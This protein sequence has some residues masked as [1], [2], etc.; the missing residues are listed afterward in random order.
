VTAGI[1]GLA[2][3]IGG[4]FFS[5][6]G[7]PMI[8]QNADILLLGPLLFGPISILYLEAESAVMRAGYYSGV[9]L[10]SRAKELCGHTDRGVLGWESFRATHEGKLSAI[11][12]PDN[13]HFS[14][15]KIMLFELP[16]LVFLGAYIY[17]RISPAG[18]LFTWHPML[19]CLLLVVDTEIV[20]YCIDRFVKALDDVRTLNN[21]AAE[22][23]F[24]VGN[25]NVR[26]T[27]TNVNT[28]SDYLNNIGRWGG[29]LNSWLYRLLWLDGVFFLAFFCFLP[30]VEIDLQHA[31]QNRILYAGLAI[32]IVGT[33]V[34]SL[35][36][37][38][39][40]ESWYWLIPM[41]VCCAIW[42]FFWWNRNLY[43][44]PMRLA[45]D[46]EN[47]DLA[48]QSILKHEEQ[49]WNSPG[50]RSAESD[51]LPEADFTTL[52]GQTFQA[53]D[54][55]DRLNYTLG[56]RLN[57]THMRFEPPAVRDMSP[58]V[59]SLDVDQ[60]VTGLPQS[61]RIMNTTSKN[62]LRIHTKYLLVQKDGSWR[63]ASGQSTPQID[64]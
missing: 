34:A 33:L 43:E 32:G 62:V 13:L 58:G 39:K 45:A 47:G 18:Y 59:K 63:I 24:E 27:G 12:R 22:L 28:R 9:E 52:D 1:G 55:E 29:L 42:G 31:W 30:A 4:V 61:S 26:S 5:Q 48:V 49:A 14:L 23:L 53:R 6:Y 50:H 36:S 3:T 54:I 11:S 40:R 51:Y 60:E 46:I 2:A 20:L 8:V 38:H 64:R 19:V 16:C 35:E 15:P 44:V 37:F 7:H 57:G 21:K 17:L 41:F 56:G 25:N 10:Q